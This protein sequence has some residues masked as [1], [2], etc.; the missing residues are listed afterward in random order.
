[1]AFALAIVVPLI[2]NIYKTSLVE[3]LE[4]YMRVSIKDYDDISVNPVTIFWNELQEKVK[5]S[6]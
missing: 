3:K 6:K 4:R 5:T 2:L 1:M